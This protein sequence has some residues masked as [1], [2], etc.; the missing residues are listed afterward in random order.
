MADRMQLLETF[1]GAPKCTLWRYTCPVELIEQLAQDGSRY[2]P[3]FDVGGIAWRLHLQQRTAPQSDDVFLA[4]HLQCC[5]PQGAYGH[6]RITVCNKDPSCAKSKTFHCH[7]KKSGSAWGLHH[8]IGLDRLLAY[9]GGFVDDGVVNSARR[10]TGAPPA[11]YIDVTINI[12]EAGPDGNYS[13]GTLPT[14]TKSVFPT[15]QY[16]AV[17]AQRADPA[18]QYMPAPSRSASSRTAPVASIDPLS[19]QHVKASLVYPFDHL[20]GLC[21]MWFDVSGVKIKAHRCVV[22]ARMGPLIPQSLL[23]L[24]EGAT[25]PIVTPMDVFAAFLRYVYTEDY[26]EPGVL[27][28]ESLLDMYMLAAACEFYDLAGICLKYVRPLLTH[29]NILPIVLSKYN[30]SDEILTNMYLRL[31]LDNYDFLIQDKQF[32]EIPGHLFRRLSLIL[33]DKEKLPPVQ[34]PPSKNT[35]GRQLAVLSESGEYADYDLVVGD[36]GHVLPAH[37]YILASRSVLFSQAFSKRAPGSIPSFQHPEFGFSLRSWQR[38]MQAVYR[39]QL[40]WSAG[41]GGAGGDVSAEEICICHKLSAAWSM[42][43]QLRKDAEQALNV[44]NALRVLIYAVKHQVPELREKATQHIGANF[45]A[46]I[47]TDPQAWDLVAELP[48]QAVVSLLR[49]VVDNQR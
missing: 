7:F 38:L 39:R 18:S 2:S 44:H 23:P 35:L 32:E 15:V 10:Y 26:P 25:I 47:R 5:S 27:R 41:K 14:G 49:T 12:L 48:Q 33:R 1:S 17:P 40:D 42:D 21:D 30:S 22:G 43:G 19:F 3:E 36:A 24:Q 4:I 11:I 13:M 8:F 9:E 16:S 31:L 34:I 28:A 46:M 20:E 29:E 37:K 45:A 6:F